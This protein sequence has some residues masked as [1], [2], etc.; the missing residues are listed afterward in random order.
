VSIGCEERDGA[1]WF[2]VRDTGI[3]IPED[4]LESIFAPFV[5]VRSDLTREHGGTGLGLAISRSVAE[6]MG[7]SLTVDSVVGAGSTFTLRLPLA[8]GSPLGRQG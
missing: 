6:A 7:G 1:A 4:R 3:G 2:A 8:H 5:Q